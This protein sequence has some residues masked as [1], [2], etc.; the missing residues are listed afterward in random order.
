MDTLRFLLKHGADATLAST[1]PDGFTP[2]MSAAFNNNVEAL[3]ILID[4]GCDLKVK[5]GLDETALDVAIIEGSKEAV[6]VLLEKSG[7]GFYHPKDSVSLQM[8]MARSHTEIKAL[9]TASSLMYPYA[10]FKFEVPGEFAWMEWVLNEGGVLV[11]A[12]AMRKLL[13]MALEEQNVSRL[14]QLRFERPLIFSG[15][16]GQSSCQ[17]WLRYQYPSRVW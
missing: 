9:S 8:A 12:R 2:V 7:R 6:Q 4:H 14:M 3:T 1:K 5:N 13:H 16:N 11:K 17:S 10:G 15:W